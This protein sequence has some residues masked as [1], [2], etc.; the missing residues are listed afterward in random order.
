MEF[1]ALFASAVLS[2][3]PILLSAQPLTTPW[4]GYGHDAQH[5]GVSAT[6]AQNLNRV[7]WSTPVGRTT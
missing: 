3:V 7:K 5:S 1:R 6:A 4:S 2:G